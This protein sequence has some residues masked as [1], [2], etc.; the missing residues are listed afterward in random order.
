MTPTKQPFT[1]SKNVQS[2]TP[3]RWG[4]RN[5]NDTQKRHGVRGKR[6]KDKQPRKKK[7][8]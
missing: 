4:H 2:V 6:G 1:F 7:T 3:I 5:G 8:N